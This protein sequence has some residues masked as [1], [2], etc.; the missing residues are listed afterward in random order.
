VHEITT[1]NSSVCVNGRWTELVVGGDQGKSANGQENYS[2]PDE[3]CENT[4]YIAVYNEDRC[5]PAGG[6]PAHAGVPI[7]P[8]PSHCP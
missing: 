6:D 5:L 4:E 7:V 2:Y 3:S 1:G 8:I